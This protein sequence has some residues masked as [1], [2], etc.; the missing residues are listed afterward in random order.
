MLY[1]NFLFFGVSG[2]GEI[3]YIKE[4]MAFT[5]SYFFKLMPAT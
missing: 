4:Q 5:K 1:E 2:E 3:L